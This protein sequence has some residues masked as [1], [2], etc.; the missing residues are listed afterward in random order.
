MCRNTLRI[1]PQHPAAGIVLSEKAGARTRWQGRSR[2]FSQM[3]VV[4][5]QRRIE[6]R[7]SAYHIAENAEKGT[8][9]R[10]AARRMQPRSCSVVWQ[11]M[12]R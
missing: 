8:R 2:G 7:I 1:E 9:E 6:G 4:E 5:S 11:E 10:A 3:N 12:G